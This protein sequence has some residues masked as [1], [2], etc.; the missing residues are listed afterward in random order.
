MTASSDGS[1][2][3][4]Q[5]LFQLAAAGAGSLLAPAALADTQLLRATRVDNPL[6]SYPN[7]DWE[8][9]YRDLYR[10]D[11]TFTFLC[12]PN[13]T[14]NCLLRAH[15]KNG[16]VTRIAPSYGYHLA[17]DLAG[18]KASR[19]WDPRCCQKGLALVRRFY[20]DRRVKRPTVRRGY[21]QWIEAGCPRDP[22]TGAVDKKWLQRGRDAWE[23]VSW[24][25]A[26]ELAARGLV[27]IARTYSGAEG[28][29]RLT[30][31]GYDPLMVEATGGAGTQVLKFRGGM[32]ALGVTRIMAQYRLANAMALLDDKVRG[33]GREKAVG[34][35]GWDNYAW[36]TDLPPGH[37]MVVGQATNEYDLCNVEHAGLVLVWGMNWIATKMPCSHW[38]TEARLKGTKIV[39]IAAEYSA[40]ANKGDEVVV[41]RPGTTP[42]LAL[43][44]AQVIISEKLY[45]ATEVK[46]RT[47]L[48]CL[49]RMDTGELLKAKETFPDHVHAP[50]TN[51]VTVLAEGQQPAPNHQQAGPVITQAQR[52]AW[53]D[54]VMWDE[55][56]GAPV[57][58]DR[59]HIGGRFAALG[60]DP[61]LEG[62]VEVTL[63]SGEKVACRTVF[64]VTRELL[65]GS[66]TPGDV[67]K[68][69]W[70]PAAVV[71]SLA[72]QVAANQER[73]IFAL[74][75]GPNQFFNSDL[76]DR[77]VFLV[78]ALTRNV[79]RAGGNVGSYAGNYRSAM[80]SGV[81]QYASEDPFDPELDPAKPART[82]A[83]LRTESVHYFNHGDT[84]LRYGKGVLTG[85]THMPTPTK[86]VCVSNSNSLIGNAKGHYETVVNGLP[87][88]EL[89]VVNEWWWTGSCEY[90]D[91][92]F[93]VDSW[94][95]LKYPDMTISVT[96]PFLYVFPV[97]P[98]HRIHNTRS[99]VDVAAGLSRAV[100]RLTDDPRHDA[101]WRFVADGAM[102]PYLQRILD[103]SNLM[104][105]YRIEVLERK[106]EEGTPAMVLSRTYPKW[107]SWEQIFEDK[108]W[109]TRSGRMEFYRDEPEFRASGEN[110]VLHREPIDSTF[111][112][113]N[114][115]VARAHPLLRPTTPEEYGADRSDLSGDA[116]QARHVIK[117]VDELM[118]TRHPLME[119]GH[120]LIFHT[121]KYRHGAHTTPVDTD[122]VSVWFGPFGD[123]YRH[124]KRIPFVNELFVDMNPAD[125]KRLG[126]EDG[127][128]V[129][130]DADPKD[131]PY[132][133]WKAGTEE[134][135]LAR[136][137]A[138]ARYYPGTPVGVTRMWHN[139]YGSTYGSVRGHESD[140]TG[141]AKSPET[142]YQAMFRYGS[143][144][145]CTRGWLKPT[146]M[147]DSLHVKD[148]YGQRI[149][150][151]WVPDVHGPTGAPREAMVKITRA[152]AGGVGGEGLWRPARLG[153]RPTYEGAALKKFIGGEFVQ[154]A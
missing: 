33:T 148:L 60:I 28:Q 139:A 147:T 77:A 17:T 125:C 51:H 14:H 6:A 73:T 58:V 68:L 144:Q 84:I 149:V 115:I 49:I 80:F 126:I 72:R 30:A 81:P 103:H 140:P 50:L 104:R 100:G 105:G 111:F 37:P 92:V 90:A 13:D 99:D 7:R 8:Q 91:V 9:A 34:A 102:R 74:G 3:R 101:Y 26:L 39:V 116:R 112:E 1:L 61:R 110:L 108:P 79:G 109:Y 18:N 131:R 20:G 12:A 57:A 136:L 135:K 117:S 146:W 29:A 128:Y 113:P 96:N 42:A 98:L 54:L 145:S 121:P 48:P 129:W 64:D 106:A 151:G 95:E 138:R 32:A 63:A 150:Q 130:I 62:A 65:D 43:G 5:F 122:I 69:T 127:D 83:Y 59:D 86:S 87:K 56:T 24:D 19:R 44:L 124:D 21:K 154:R 134:Y 82:R 152:E 15:V 40:T 25:Q 120:D 66:Y 31:Q 143:H 85:K 23:A 67:E 47:D 97:T 89:V 41:V 11:S 119:G 53:G 38:L 133:H 153:L 16:V 107:S 35:R 22:Q 94:A 142:D 114:V 132:H 4:R 52:E 55:L 10:S 88:V 27:D 76:K 75:M 45:D 36:H 70:C 123:M 2:S 118:K 141:L 78:A 71:T 93:P 137:M 46:T